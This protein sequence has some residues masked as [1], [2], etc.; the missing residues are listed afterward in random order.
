MKIMSKNITEYIQGK[1]AIN[2]DNIESVAILRSSHWFIQRFVNTTN[3]LFP[4][5]PH[6]SLLQK[7]PTNTK[8]PFHFNNSHSETTSGHRH[9]KGCRHQTTH[10]CVKGAIRCACPSPGKFS[11]PRL[12]GEHTS[13]AGP[14][15]AQTSRQAPHTR[16]KLH[17]LSASS[18]HSR[19]C[20]A[21]AQRQKETSADAVKAPGVRCSTTC[22]PGS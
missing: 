4:F 19:Q 5:L 13:P 21:S 22:F 7:N 14:S 20:R 15:P 10:E 8:K 12:P 6:D 1:T 11:T 16:A 2:I 3:T 17:T 9:K 18:T